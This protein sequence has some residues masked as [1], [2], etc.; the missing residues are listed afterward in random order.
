MSLLSTI[1]PPPTVLIS[2]NC[3]PGTSVLG[4]K[5]LLQR[6]LHIYKA[7]YTGP[8][9]ELSVQLSN[10]YAAVMSSRPVDHFLNVSLTVQRKGNSLNMVSDLRTHPTKETENLLGGIRHLNLPVQELLTKS[11]LRSLFPTMGPYL[12]LRLTASL[13]QSPSQL[14]QGTGLLGNLD[15]E[16]QEESETS[17]QSSTP[18]HSTN[19]GTDLETRQRS[20]LM[21]STPLTPNGSE[22]SSKSGPIIMDSSPKRKGSPSLV[23]P[24]ELFVRP[25]TPLKNSSPTTSSWLKRSKDVSWSSNVL[26]GLH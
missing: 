18:N 22:D 15:V 13:F 21:M 9:P 4:R 17:S 2:V 24:D 1:G 10:S 12:E 23:D 25:S 26:T 19:G 14:P 6:I 11:M 3:P 16:N 5:S 8:M 7:L 20:L